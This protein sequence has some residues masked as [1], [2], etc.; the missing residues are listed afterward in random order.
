[1]ARAHSSPSAIKDNS[2]RQQYPVTVAG[3]LKTITHFTRLPG[4]RKPPLLEFNNC[5]IYCAS[6]DFYIDP[7]K[8]VKYAVITHAH[9]DHARWG[10]AHYLAHKLSLE[11]LTYRL[12]DISVQ[13]VSY[14]ETII[15]N[16]VKISFH[17]AG[18]IIGS[19]QIRV[20]YKGEVWVVSGDYKL[21]D[22]G[23][24]APFEPVKCH[25]F[26]SECTFGMPVY[27]WKPQKEIFEDINHWWQQNIADGRNT[28]LAGYSLGKAQR[29][30][31]SLDPAIGRIY[32]HGAIENTNDALRRNGVNLPETIR[33]TPE[34]NK[35]DL[36][37]GI[38]LC[39]PSAIGTAWMRKFQPLNFGYCSGWMALRG[40]KR[41]MAADRGFVIS[42]HA[43]WDGLISAIQATTC[44]S[45]YLTHGYTA[46]FARYLSDIG[47]DA[48]EAKTGYG[49]DETSELDELPVE[50][51]NAHGELIT[52]GED[53]NPSTAENDEKL[54]Q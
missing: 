29:I 8:P 18:H 12:G 47:F 14:N 11:V 53:E 52:E 10:H 51:T 17:P 46:P 43:D 5:G 50:L 25:A 31:H 1:M 35:N 6:G 9:S 49:G 27:K 2:S 7:W 33:I 3:R 54:S 34:I 26:I 39:P 32:T 36:R 44:E 21:E 30:M 23:V 38:I 4:M 19:S 41:R 48:H 40:A 24:A 16:G 13:T 22:D 37:N 45:V 28:V 42:D 20:E 15:R